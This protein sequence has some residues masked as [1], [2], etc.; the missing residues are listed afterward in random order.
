LLQI[1]IFNNFAASPASEPQGPQTTVQQVDDSEDEGTEQISSV[2]ALCDILTKESQVI[3]I[4]T[5][6]RTQDH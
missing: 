1:Q 6:N 2:K 3:K 4:Q 5:F